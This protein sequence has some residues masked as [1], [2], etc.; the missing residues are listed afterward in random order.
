MTAPP[1]IREAAAGFR[2]GSLSPVEVTRAAL[3]RI[4]AIDERVRAF[5]HVAADEALRAASGAEASFR[6]GID[7]GPLQGVP[8][9]VK[10]IFDVE[11]VETSG[12]SQVLAGRVPPRD[13]ELVARLRQ[14]G[15]VLLGTVRAHEFAYGVVTPPTRNPWNLERVPGGSS[16]GS[17]AA[18]SA[19]ECLL[20]TG[21]DT[22]GSIRIPA[23]ACGVVGL[24]PTYGLVSTA[25]MLP[26]AWSLDHAG[27][28]A[29]TAAD[30][31]LAMSVMAPDEWSDAFATCVGRGVDG[32]VLGVPSNYFFDDLQPAVEGA[33]RRAIADLESLG[34]RVRDVEVPFAERGVAI[35]FATCLAEAASIHEP[36]YRE[37]PDLY[38]DDVRLYL[39]VG[40]TRPAVEY[41][42]A[43]RA[44]SRLR[45]LWLEAMEGLDALVAPTLPATAARVGSGAVDLPSGRVDVVT[46][47]LRCTAPV[48][49]VGLPALSVPCGW[50][51]DG[52][53]IGLQVI[54]R[55]HADDDVLRIGHAYQTL[56]DWTS[57][58]ALAGREEHATRAGGQWGLPPR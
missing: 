7:R 33:V 52:L 50:D 56:R 9:A 43:R 31:A 8:I 26:L 24:K 27:P 17:A 55:P 57:V 47:Y 42:R 4:E 49:V 15:A 21:S 11:G 2:D 1:S 38:G 39:E 29:R 20:A 10:D 46:A 12:S 53:P 19:G 48:N 30:V 32:L 44:A 58:D 36:L 34:A 51:P 5:S 18:V 54:G 37:H 22:G 25:G 3:E 41:L 13:S 40:F 16:G 35:A 45:Q 23:S 14:G 28:I 6:S